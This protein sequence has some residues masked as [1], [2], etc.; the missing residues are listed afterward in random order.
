[1]LQVSYLYQEYTTIVKSYSIL[2]NV[3]GFFKLLKKF[4]NK[5]IYI[6]I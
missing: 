3:Q 6:Y 1:M 4:F 2:A 5:Y